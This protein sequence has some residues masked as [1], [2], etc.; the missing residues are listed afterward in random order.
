MKK[1]LKTNLFI[2]MD[3]EKIESILSEKYEYL[4][5][6]EFM[7]KYELVLLEVVDV[8]YQNNEIKAYSFDVKFDSNESN[9]GN[10]LT[11]GHML[12]KANEEIIEFLY[13]YPVNPKTYQIDTKFESFSVNDGLFMNFD[14]KFD[15]LHMMDISYFI[16]Y[17]IY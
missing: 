12:S 8:E 16:T 10:A 3:R 1:Y 14:Y 7:R 17:D 5:K 9:D 6:N 4:F 13:K 15:E 11:I 2:V